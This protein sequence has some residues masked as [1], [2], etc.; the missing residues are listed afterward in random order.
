MLRLDHF[1]PYRLS[2]ASNAVSEV[3]AG[4]YE[5]IGLSIPEWRLIAVLSEQRRATQQMLC[6]LTRMDKVTVSRAAAGLTERG[7]LLRAPNA[8]DRRSHF[9]SLSAA[10]RA[11]YKEVA[12]RALAMEKTLLAGFKASEIALLEKMLRRLED[13]AGVHAEESAER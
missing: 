13:A 8:E 10:G 12:P 11:V 6:G 9:L 7:L 5:E 4:A 2:V 3:I 1:L